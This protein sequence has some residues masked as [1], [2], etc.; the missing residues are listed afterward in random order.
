VWGYKL[1]FIISQ[2]SFDAHSLE[3]KKKEKRRKKIGTDQSWQ[4]ES[5][6]VYQIYY[7]AGTSD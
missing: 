3:Q 7:C 5:Y 1:L 6:D 2:K 4:R